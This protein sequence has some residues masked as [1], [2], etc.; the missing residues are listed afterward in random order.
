[1]NGIIFHR[2]SWSVPELSVK[3][4]NA[5]TRSFVE[6]FDF[7]VDEG[8]PFQGFFKHRDGGRGAKRAKPVYFDASSVASMVTLG[9]RL[10]ELERY[11]LLQE[12]F[13]VPV[14]GERAMEIML[15]AKV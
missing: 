15:N 3:L 7:W 6:M 1:M 11:G 14:D 4:G 5:M 12:A 10:G 2:R 8:L 9:R 13:P